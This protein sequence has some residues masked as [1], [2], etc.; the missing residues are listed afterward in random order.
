MTA[1][2]VAS[3]RAR[4]PRSNDCK[5]FFGKQEQHADG[6]CRKVRRAEVFCVGQSRSTV[7]ASYAAHCLY[8]ND[9]LVAKYCRK[10][11]RHVGRRYSAWQPHQPVVRERVFA[12]TGQARKAYAAYLA[13]RS[14]LRRLRNVYV[15]THG[16]FRACGEGKYISY[17]TA[18]RRA[19]P[20]QGA[21]AYVVAG[22]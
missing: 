12:R 11:F 18:L 1:I 16:R 4:M 21:C 6:V 7:A 10:F 22:R 2:R 15:V 3:A 5:G 20:K 9:G 19:T 14:L 13:L 17:G 8:T